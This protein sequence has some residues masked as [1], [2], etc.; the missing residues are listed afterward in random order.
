MKISNGYEHQLF[1]ISTILDQVEITFVDVTDPFPSHYESTKLASLTRINR[2]LY[3]YHIC[4][5][6]YLSNK[7]IS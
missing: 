1:S 6:L 3:C 7:W 4:E 5:I 2:V